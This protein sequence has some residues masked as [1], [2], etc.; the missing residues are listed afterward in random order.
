MKKNIGN[1]DRIIRL[2]LAALVGFLYFTNVISGTPGIILLI[3]GIVLLLTSVV[4]TC[5]LYSL[6]GFNTSAA[7]K[8]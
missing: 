8:I 2:L 7:K 5:P 1:A 6:F 3:V 4:G